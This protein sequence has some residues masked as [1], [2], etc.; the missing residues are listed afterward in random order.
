MEQRGDYKNGVWLAVAAFAWWGLVPLYFKAV[1][2]VGAL[3]ILA[4]RVLW[5]VPVAALLV[6]LDRGWPRLLADL[7][8]RQVVATLALTSVLVASNWLLFIYCVETGR[9]LESSLGYFI[10]PLLN[11]LLGVVFLGER[12]TRLQI[13]AVVLAGLGTLNLVLEHGGVPWLSLGLAFTFSIYGLLRKRVAIESLG[14]LFME[15]LLLAPL[16]LG[17]LIWAGHAGSLAFV[18]GGWGLGLLL[19]SAGIVTALPLVWFTAGARRIPYYV[20]GLL[21]YIGPSLQ[22]T[23]AVMVFDEPLDRA[24]LVTFALVWAGIALFILAGVPA[25]REARRLAQGRD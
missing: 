23:L 3:E 20:L 2:G 9:V 25:W 21:Q 22:F 10:C 13:G 18:Q 4:H 6:S 5:S 14:G 24:R 19:M 11:V 17:W 1:A 8:N 7:A 16:A 15:T 12:P